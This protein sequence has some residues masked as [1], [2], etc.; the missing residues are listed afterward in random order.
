M[1][2]WHNV[3]IWSIYFIN[4]CLV[5][6]GST[7]G[8]IHGTPVGT[9]FFCDKTQFYK[10]MTCLCTAVPWKPIIHQLNGGKYIDRWQT[11][12]H[13]NIF[14]HCS[15]TPWRFYEHRT[16]K[17]VW[18][19]HSKT[20]LRQDIYVDCFVVYWIILSYLFPGHY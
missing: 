20:I 3:S 2:E 19:S 11:L 9:Q 17:N 5:R 16:W 12:K 4:K 1:I 10:T 15:V 14:C 18:D 13:I 6:I 8:G 7:R